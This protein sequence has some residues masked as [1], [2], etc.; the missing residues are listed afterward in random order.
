MKE[1]DLEKLITMAASQVGARLFRNNVGTG[2]T[3]Q[4]TRLSDGSVHIQNPRILH[5]GLMKGSAD[6]IGWMP[7]VITPDMVGK[8]IA[9]FAS[10]EVKSGS[11]LTPDQITWMNTVLAFGGIAGMAKTPQ[12]AVGILTQHRLNL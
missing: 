10:I 11:R 5:A 3:G 12:Q 9:V 6:Q 8:T 2:Y 4:A 1:S 7:V